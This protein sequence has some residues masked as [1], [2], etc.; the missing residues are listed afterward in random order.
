MAGRT[1]TPAT[2]WYV[3]RSDDKP[4]AR[5]ETINLILNQIKYTGRI[6]RLDF[7]PDP[8]VVIRGDQE[9]KNMQKRKRKHGTFVR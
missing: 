7:S 4:H 2:P 9:L 5:L 8:D 3:I 1:H 6:R